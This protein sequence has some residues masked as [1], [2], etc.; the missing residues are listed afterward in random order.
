MAERNDTFENH[1]P[2]GGSAS[3]P[4]AWPRLVI[5]ARAHAEPSLETGSLYTAHENTFLKLPTFKN[6]EMLC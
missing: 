5:A 2:A 3:L 4:E 6:R 1:S